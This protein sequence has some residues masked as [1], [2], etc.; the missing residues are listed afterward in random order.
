[1]LIGGDP[2]L[3]GRSQQL[4]ALTARHGIPAIYNFRENVLVGGLM[5]HGSNSPKDY[6]Q[7]GVYAGRLLKGE[8]V[9]FAV[10]VSGPIRFRH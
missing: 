1:M 5:S 2:F 9:P 6:R 10:H 3:V 8:G 4:V 7:L